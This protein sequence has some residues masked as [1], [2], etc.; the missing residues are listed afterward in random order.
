MRMSHDGNPYTDET[1]VMRCSMVVHDSGRVSAHGD[2][3]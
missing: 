2:N 1:I 3:T